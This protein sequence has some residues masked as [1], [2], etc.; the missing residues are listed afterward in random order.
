MNLLAKYERR[1]SNGSE[2]NDSLYNEIAMK[3]DEYN[4]PAID[5]KIDPIWKA[6]PGYNGIEVDV[7]AS[8]KKMKKDG[9]I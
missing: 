5:A 7:E 4:V 8:Y 1:Y 9:T 3:A 6:I 2:T